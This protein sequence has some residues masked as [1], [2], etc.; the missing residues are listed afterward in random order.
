VWVSGTSCPDLAVAAVVA[1]LGLSSA[2]RIARQAIVE[3]RGGDA[4][5]PLP[6][7]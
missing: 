3:M 2:V 1:C 5:I 6:A 7:E 4:F